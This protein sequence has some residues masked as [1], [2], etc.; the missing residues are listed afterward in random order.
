M[1]PP[2]FSDSKNLGSGLAIPY[3][4]AVDN[5][6]NFTLTSRLFVDEHPLIIGEYHQA[7]KN[8]SFLTDFGFTEGYK[9]TSKT[10]KAGDKSHFFSKFTKTF[11][12]KS[13]SENTF[14]FKTQDVSNDKYLKLYRIKSNLVDYNTDVLENSIDY[15]HSKDDLFFG[16]KASVYETLKDDYNDKYEY[17]LPE[18][19]I[20]KNIFGSEKFGN[21]NL[22]SN[23][24]VHN[25][26]TNK[27][28]NFLVND[29]EW[30]SN[31]FIFD[32]NIKA[33]F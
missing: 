31:D 1:L 3:F 33:Q 10:K 14:S 2:T 4:L 22:Q 20:D 27:H 7:F 32:S 9:N 13:G 6:K 11:S 25:Y 5:D 18:I 19:T 24:K 17:I 30:T 29:F 15:S 16:L 26:D 12:G 8:S 28:T 21:L 23:L